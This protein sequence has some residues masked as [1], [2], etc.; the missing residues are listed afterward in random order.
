[1][2]SPFITLAE[3]AINSIK[4][5]LAKTL[6]DVK[7]SHRAEALARG[8]GLNTYASL[9]AATKGAHYHSASFEWKGASTYLA[10]HGF[11]P[12]AKPFFIAV[13]RCAVQE[14]LQQEPILTMS[15]LGDGGPHRKADGTRETAEEQVLRFRKWRAEFMAD[16]SIEQFL[17][18]VDLVGRFKKIKTINKKAFSYGLK[19]TA[20]KR[21]CAYPD[22]EILG[23]NYVSNGALIAAA[24]NV[25]FVYKRDGN[26]LNAFFNMSQKSIEEAWA[27]NKAQEDG[28]G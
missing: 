25:G 7:S 5:E 28:E 26:S 23:P 10:N 15:G 20:E 9:L 27:L 19:H 21:F 11:F 8:L 13:G 12:P 3:S 22:G 24:I 4:A 18:A 6:P 14:V 1:M 16:Q 17:R 2:F